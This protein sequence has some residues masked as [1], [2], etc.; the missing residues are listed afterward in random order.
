M[1]SAMKVSAAET[2]QQILQKAIVEGEN[3][4]SKK[5]K[6]T[7]CFY[8]S[9]VTTVYSTD[10]KILPIKERSESYSQGDLFYLKNDRAEIVDDGKNTFTVFN[11]QKK[12]YWSTSEGQELEKS[13]QNFINSKL[14][15]GAKFSVIDKNEAFEIKVIVSDSI[16]KS[17]GVVAFIYT[18]NKKYEFKAARMI[19]NK[20]KSKETKTASIIYQFSKRAIVDL[21]VVLQNSSENYFLERNKLKSK[22]VKQG[23]ELVDYRKK[24]TKKIVKKN[25]KESEK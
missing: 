17:D 19:L 13:K 11:H 9:F 8:M 12:I 16:N 15:K 18:I 23:Y 2:A 6:K 3:Y 20:Q 14:F 22:F 25:I 5:L 24:T 1:S 4:A 7:S 21:P 10:A